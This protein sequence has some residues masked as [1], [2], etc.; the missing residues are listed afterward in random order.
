[1]HQTDAKDSSPIDISTRFYNVY[2][3]LRLVGEV[4]RAF[5]GAPVVGVEIGVEVR[6]FVVDGETQIGDLVALRHEHALVEGTDFEQGVDRGL[7]RHGLQGTA[8]KILAAGAVKVGGG[9]KDSQVVT[10][11]NRFGIF[12]KETAVGLQVDYAALFQDFTVAL[13]KKRAGQAAVLAL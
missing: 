5:L 13:R 1:M 6:A 4:A 3:F 8:G 9:G 10:L 2:S 11:G 12:I 7:A